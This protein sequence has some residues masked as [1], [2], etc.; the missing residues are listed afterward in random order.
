MREIFRAASKEPKAGQIELRGVLP[1]ERVE[2]GNKLL[3]DNLDDV[4]LTL[5]C[6]GIALGGPG[7][8]WDCLGIAW[9]GGAG[10]GLPG[11]S[12]GRPRAGVGLSG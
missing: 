4:E 10:R 2:P 1:G 5:D 6:L 12:L 8:V 11:N 9:G 7:Q 3:P